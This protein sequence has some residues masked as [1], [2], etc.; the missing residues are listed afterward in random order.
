MAKLYD[1]KGS[2]PREKIL[3]DKTIRKSGVEKDSIKDRVTE[4]KLP[5]SGHVPDPDPDGD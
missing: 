5:S 2:N 1:P 4:A 3:D